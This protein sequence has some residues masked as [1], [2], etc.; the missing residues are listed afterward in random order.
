MSAIAAE[1]RFF[2][3]L[4]EM[5]DRNVTVI[6]TKGE[7][8][9]GSLAGFH[10]ATMTICL[11]DARDDKGNELGKLILSGNV[12]AE[13]FTAERGLDLR[14]L[15]DRL[16]ALFPNAVELHEDE[17]VITVLRNIR[18]SE[19]GVEG[20][21]GPIYDRVKKVYEEFMKQKAAR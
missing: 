5:L 3:E 14:A 6:T 7:R 8:F 18:V 1:R 13:I 19:R 4:S 11:T 15:Y 2:K 16:S 21:P 20:P 17:G 9:M 10:S 12:I